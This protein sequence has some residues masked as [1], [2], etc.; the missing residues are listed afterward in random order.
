MGLRMLWSLQYKGSNPAI[1]LRKVEHVLGLRP[2]GSGSRPFVDQSHF[3]QFFSNLKADNWEGAVVEALDLASSYSR[4]WTVT[5]SPGR[6]HA[7][8]VERKVAEATGL[9][10]ELNAAQYFQTEVEFASLDR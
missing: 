3:I 9:S 5:V 8:T 2:S 7:S 4:Q 10:F 1:G 6:L